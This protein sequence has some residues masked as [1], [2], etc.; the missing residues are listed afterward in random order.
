MQTTSPNRTSKRSITLLKSAPTTP[1]G[2][3]RSSITFEEAVS[4]YERYLAT[5]GLELNARDR[6]L[7]FLDCEESEVE[8][9]PKDVRLV[10]A[11]AEFSKEITTTV[12]WLNDNGHDIKCVRL[13]PYND[14]GRLLIDVQQ[15]IPLPEAEAY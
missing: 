14:A 2:G 12:L 15:V 11:A 7:E 4:T 3:W 13:R 6:I 5:N 8:D 10:L 9:S 1:R